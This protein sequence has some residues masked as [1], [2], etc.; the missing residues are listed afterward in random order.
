MEQCF[1]PFAATLCRDRVPYKDLAAELNN[2]VSAL[3]AEVDKR[4]RELQPGLSASCRQRARMSP[5]DL[6]AT[7]AA[8]AN[9][10]QRVLP[11][12]PSSYWH[13]R[14]LEEKDWLGLAAQLYSELFSPEFLVPLL[15][16]DLAFRLEA[17]D[18]DLS[19]YKELLQTHGSVDLDVSRVV[20]HPKGKVHIHSPYLDLSVFNPQSSSAARTAS[21]KTKRPPWKRENV[22]GGERPSL[23]PA[24]PHPAKIALIIFNR[25]NEDPIPLDSD[26]CQQVLKAVCSGGSNTEAIGSSGASSSSPSASIQ[27]APSAEDVSLEPTGQRATYTHGGPYS[28]CV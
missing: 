3:K 13:G 14:A 27:M 24:V 23:P 18:V 22:T 9:I 2:M 1:G 25:E 10:A 4:K 17:V 16:D 7:L 6:Q 15:E 26:A 12:L 20:H 8:G 11:R 21:A 5:S 19:Q 28:T